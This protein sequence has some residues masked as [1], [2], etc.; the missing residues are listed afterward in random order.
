MS[1]TIGCLGK[2]PAYPEFIRVEASTTEVETWDEWVQ[3]GLL[4]GK[5]KRG[6][7]Y[8]AVYLSGSSIAFIWNSAGFDH[9]LIG[10]SRPSRDKAGRLYPFTVFAF[11]PK[12]DPIE[13]L[14]CIAAHFAQAAEAMPI[15]DWPDPNAATAWVK[16]FGEEYAA[17]GMPLLRINREA[18]DLPI[19]HPPAV[20]LSVV[21]NLK[22]VAQSIAESPATNLDYGLGFQFGDRPAE[23][24][25]LALAALLSRRIL[26]SLG[27]PIAMLW[28]VG[29]RSQGVLFYGKPAPAVYSGLTTGD[30]V[31]DHVFWLNGDGP[32]D[33]EMLRSE[34]PKNLVE[35]MERPHTMTADILAA[36]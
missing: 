24:A 31:S 26:P 21:H 4:I 32:P 12:S 23:D 1:F 10:Y 16:Q 11:V 14:A 30:D 9:A 15:G 35:T 13:K 18:S 34:L 17:P 28:S 20:G 2:I 8:D 6:S 36:L 33:M 29:A 27:H 19:V 7:A 3:E 5:R 25:A 22:A